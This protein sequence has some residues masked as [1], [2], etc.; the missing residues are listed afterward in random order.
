[1]K[2]KIELDISLSAIF[3]VLLT[4]AALFLLLK[5]ADILLTIFVAIIIVAAVNPLVVSLSRKM[6]RKYAALVVLLLV[7]AVITT[8]VGLLIPPIAKQ[9]SEL[10]SNLPNY[11]SQINLGLEEPTLKNS[12]YKKLIESMPSSLQQLTTRT[13]AIIINF[14]GG[15]FSVVALVFLIYYLLLE[16]AGIKKLFFSL[17]PGDKKELVADIVSKMGLKI[18]DWLRGELILMSIIGILDLIIL[19]ALGVPYALILGVWAGLTEIIPYVGPILGAIPALFFAFSISPFTAFLVLIFYAVV[20][21]LESNFL[22]PRVMQKT[23]GLSPV[24]VILALMI[25]GKLFGVL[26]VILA[27]PVAAML[28]VFK[29]EWQNIKSSLK[30]N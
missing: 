7:V 23:V 21:Q 5:I 19:L 15:I 13:P 1:V 27:V 26:G 11:L 20:Q 8:V 12:F 9:L 22:V 29:D 6:P 2:Q 14:V 17:I 28:V 18:G 10:L 24:V 25:G 3:K 30:K 4:L 16:E